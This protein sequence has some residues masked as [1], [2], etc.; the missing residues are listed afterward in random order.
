MTPFLSETAIEPSLLSLFESMGYATA[1]GPDMALMAT[2]RR[3]RI[4]ARLCWWGGCERRWNPSTRW[5][6]P[7]PEQRMRQRIWW[8]WGMKITR[9]HYNADQH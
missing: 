4:M 9:R 3:G 8:S 2:L 7:M 5:C 6:L 1:Q